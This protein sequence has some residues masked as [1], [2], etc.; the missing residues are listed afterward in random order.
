M[1]LWTPCQC[2]RSFERRSKPSWPSTTLRGPSPSDGAS[3]PIRRRLRAGARS[4]KNKAMSNPQDFLA[5]WSQRKR[6]AGRKASEQEPPATPI[7]GSASDGR[8]ALYGPLPVSGGG[9]ANA[10]AEFDLSQLPSVESITAETDIRAFLAPGVPV[11]LVRAALRRGWAADPAIR[12]HIG[13]SENSWDFNAPSAMPGFGPLE[14]TDDLRHAVDRILGSS[15]ERLQAVANAHPAEAAP[16][17]AANDTTTCD[18]PQE[19]QE[20]HECD[21]NATA[22]RQKCCGA[23]NF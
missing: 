7:P 13:L 12:D 4:T 8:D 2:R 15:A 17:Q 10:A 19:T 14:M 21:E 1:I 23:N 6:E 18:V 20:S 11:E 16:Q 5:R 3:A 22:Q 9:D